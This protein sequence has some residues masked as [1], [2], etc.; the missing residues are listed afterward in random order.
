[1]EAD[2]GAARLEGFSDAVFG[3]AIT[4][5]VVSLEVPSTFDDLLA[6]FRALPGFAITFAVLLSVWQEH[7]RF[8]RK[9]PA[10]D[11]VTIWLNGGLLF[12]VIVYVYPLK[13]LFGLLTGPRGLRLGTGR[14]HMIRPEQIVSAMVLYGVGFLAMFALLG[15]LYATAWRRCQQ[16]QRREGQEEALEGMRHCCVYVVVALLSIAVA[17]LGRGRPAAGLASGMCYVLIAP[18]HILLRRRRSGRAARR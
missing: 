6:V 12:T 15:G 16:A 11:G 5:L 14:Q 2:G 1:M 4:L 8:F 3:F 18:L 13:F 17:L 9:F 10:S 7:H